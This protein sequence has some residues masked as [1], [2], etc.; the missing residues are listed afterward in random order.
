MATPFHGRADWGARPPRSRTSIPA[1]EG[2]TAHYGGPSPWSGSIDRSTPE[3]F[4]ATAD[5]ARCATIMRAYQ[6]FHM[7]SRGWSDFAYNSAAC[8]H[9]HR[10]EGRGPGVRSAAQGTTAGNDR[11]YATVYLAGAA[12]PLT[13]P[14]QRAYLDEGGRL[15]RL[16]WGH[17]DWK[18]TACPGAPLY[19]W[20]TAGFPTPD[21]PP[22]DDMFE[23]SDSDRLL[24]IEKMLD[25]R[26]FQEGFSAVDDIFFRAQGADIKAAQTLARVAALESAVAQLGAGAAV[27]DYGRVQEA[28]EGALAKVQVTV[29]VDED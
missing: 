22:E 11:S 20:R 24:R 5:H 15:M 10:F 2:D 17:R 16:R 8:P 29:S 6:A 12:D 3:R 4:M 7:D 1:A 18:S 21:T 23:K 25:Q 27:I 14:A 9:G 19:A 26:T 28:A 13:E